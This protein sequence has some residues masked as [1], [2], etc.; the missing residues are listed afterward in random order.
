LKDILQY[1]PLIIL[2]GTLFFGQ[3]ISTRILKSELQ[4]FKNLMNAE[5]KNVTKRLDKQNGR[6]DNLEEED[7]RHLKECH[8]K[9]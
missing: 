1:W 5:L 7:K 8:I 6:I 3:I 4:S 2:F 9:K